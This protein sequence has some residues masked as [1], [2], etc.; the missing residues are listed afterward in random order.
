[1]VRS[2][3]SASWDG[4]G[5]RKLYK[6][7]VNIC[8]WHGE[9]A[10]S[11]VQVTP[12]HFWVHGFGSETEKFQMFPCDN[13]CQ[14]QEEPPVVLYKMYSAFN[15]AD[16]NEY[17]PSRPPCLTK[18]AYKSSYAM[19]NCDKTKRFRK[20]RPTRMHKSLFARKEVWIRKIYLHLPPSTPVYYQIHD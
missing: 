2:S 14:C 20:R 15:S 4:S 6:P 3:S 10:Q 13:D 19:V 5:P 16:G 11:D 9:D 17:P 18:S 1:M 7:N 8:I 12:C